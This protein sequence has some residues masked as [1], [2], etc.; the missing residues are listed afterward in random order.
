MIKSIK[1]IK[2]KEEVILFL[3]DY[4][5]K[6]INTTNNMMESNESFEKP[7]WSEYQAYQL[8]ALKAFKKVLNILPDQGVKK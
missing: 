6:C 4:L 7:S 1:D 3:Q 2:S 5:V 8:G